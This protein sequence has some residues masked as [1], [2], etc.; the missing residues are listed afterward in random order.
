MDD[1]DSTIVARL[2]A[3]RLPRRDAEPPKIKG[4]LPAKHSLMP[5]DLPPPPPQPTTVGGKRGQVII[6]EPLRSSSSSRK[7][8]HREDHSSHSD[9]ATRLTIV[10]TIHKARETLPW[11][12][13]AARG[14]VAAT[15]LDRAARIGARVGPRLLRTAWAR[16]RAL[17]DRRAAERFFHRAIILSRRDA[18][19][20]LN[21]FA[22]RRSLERALR[23]WRRA[24]RYYRRSLERDA[25]ARRIQRTLLLRKRRK[26]KSVDDNDETTAV[27]EK[28][29]RPI[30]LRRDV[31]LSPDV[32][33]SRRD[34]DF[35]AAI[36][37]TKVGHSAAKE[38]K[39]KIVIQEGHA[40]AK[41]VKREVLPAAAKI[42]KREVLPAAAKIVKREVLPAAA[43]IVKR[44]VHP[45]AEKIVKREV[46]PAA[47]KK[48]K[49]VEKT[50]VPPSAKKK[51]E[52]KKI[53]VATTTRVRH[54]AAAAAAKKKKIG[55]VPTTKVGDPAAKKIVPA[56]AP[57]RMAKQKNQAMAE[58]PAP[59]EALPTSGRDDGVVPEAK[60]EKR[61][62]RH[63]RRAVRSSEARSAERRSSS[64]KAVVE[65]KQNP[66]AGF[67]RIQRRARR[68]FWK[69]WAMAIRLQRLQRR[70]VL[71]R[72]RSQEETKQARR[73]QKMARRLSAA[74]R[75][76]RANGA[77]RSIQKR[78]RAKSAR[79]EAG[80]RAVERA[81]A[82]KAL[83]HRVAAAALVAARTRRAAAISIA[84]FSRTAACRRTAGLRAAARRHKCGV[85]ARRAVRAACASR[86]AR[87]FFVRRG[88][89][90][91]EL[92]V[93]ATLRT[94]R[95]IRQQRKKRNA[96]SAVI[97]GAWRACVRRY[98]EPVRAIARGR[99]EARAVAERRR[100]AATTVQRAARRRSAV[101]RLAVRCEARRLRDEAHRTAARRTAAAARIQTALRAKKRI[102]AER[103]SG[104]A[105]L[106]NRNVRRFLLRSLLAR[107][108]GV[109]KAR[110]E[111]EKLRVE[112]AYRER[113]DAER[114]T[115]VA[116]ETLELAKRAGWKLGSDAAGNNY[117]YNWVTGESSAEKPEGWEPEVTWVENVDVKGNVFYFDQKTGTSSWFPPCAACQA[118]EAKKICLDCD[119]LRCCDACFDEAHR[120]HRW[121]LDDASSGRRRKDALANGE[122]YCVA[123]DSRRATIVCRVCRDAYCDACFDESHKFGALAS[124]GR[125][126]FDEFRKGWHEV[127]GRVEG[128]QTYYFNATTGEST[129]QKPQALMLDE[130]LRE[131]RRYLE[132]FD[133]ANKYC[134]QVEEL[135]IE[136]ER[137]QYEKDTTLYEMK[138][139]QDADSADL[140]ELR[141]LLSRDQQNAHTKKKNGRLKIILKNP[142]KF[143]ADKRKARK[144]KRDLYRKMLLLNKDQRD[145]LL[146]L[147]RT[148]SDAASLGSPVPSLTSTMMMLDSPQKKNVGLFI[149]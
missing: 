135:Q 79:Q 111:S 63:P 37:P 66:I 75:S 10:A 15:R 84:R 124:H 60:A 88:R 126:P 35:D 103:E 87:A 100:V 129:H 134:R 70:H 74:R 136:L 59:E 51:K 43:K 125:V 65:E 28:K 99:V 53:V 113:D 14:E 12:L 36:V 82:R 97:G 4:S 71:R 106:V 38:E 61:P 8:R 44:E 26:K 62:E 109:V 20:R 141:D 2:R 147:Q 81:A 85:E 119:D 73:L 30:T 54:P 130:E 69:R 80:K 6:L 137:L 58:A 101:S 50:K 116:V 13:L 104:A 91:V 11:K 78:W 138:R 32:S 67:A 39:K 7:R 94:E 22:L 40:A 68:D 132:F 122:R 115:A 31:V 52:K 77:A 117:Y 123:C 34:A 146:L 108:F 112:T 120:D 128:E 118:A 83:A 64:R 148:S 139:R 19:S 5:S 41:I 48:E 18:I 23:R 144:R 127:K 45:A 149:N 17:A 57:S 49:I 1:E 96:A 121:R 46:H 25:A 86:I 27:A 33:R 56:A 140:E 29:R 16:W 133:S 131:H 24:A 72:R 89:V 42:V 93:L 9:L 102:V 107:R 110:L 114:A 105:S 98:S 21:A 92:R 142:L 55:V 143:Y 95:A 76:E 90:A 145:D 3:I 47:A